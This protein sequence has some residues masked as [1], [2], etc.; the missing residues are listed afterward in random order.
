MG[1]GGRVERR[2]PR[3]S[4]RVT[5]S[6]IISTTRAFLLVR[7]FSSAKNVGG[8]I[9]AEPRVVPR[10]ACRPTWRLASSMTAKLVY[11]WLSWRWAEW[12]YHVYK[13]SVCEYLPDRFRWAW[14]N[15]SSWNA[16][17]LLLD[18]NWLG[19]PRLTHACSALQWS[20]LTP[21]RSSLVVGWSLVERLRHAE[22]N[23]YWPRDVVDAT[24]WARRS[25]VLQPLKSARCRVHFFLVSQCCILVV[26]VGRVRSSGYHSLRIRCGRSTARIDGWSN[27]VQR[28]ASIT[29]TSAMRI[30]RSCRHGN[31]VEDRR[32]RVG[33]QQTR[34]N[35][36]CSAVQWKLNYESCKPLT[37]LCVWNTGV[38]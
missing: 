12:R 24:A 33:V 25:G 2:G 22:C 18:E 35:K 21:L 5:P 30:T 37:L 28:A 1:W 29:V 26:V 20:T 7:R 16:A 27:E 34:Q 9:I 6:C 15:C 10:E 19:G 36:R 4:R 14:C 38:F 17:V 31:S 32:G 23:S 3:W 11:R 8:F 13:V